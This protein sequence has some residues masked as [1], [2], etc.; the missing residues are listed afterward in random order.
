MVYLLGLILV[1]LSLLYSPSIEKSHVVYFTKT[2]TIS[3]ERNSPA[4][5]A[6]KETQKL[7]QVVKTHSEPENA[8]DS[9]PRLIA[10]LSTETIV[11]RT[12]EI[13]TVEQK[14]LQPMAFTRQELAKDTDEKIQQLVLAQKNSALY[15]AF[16]TQQ[17]FTPAFQNSHEIN[18]TKTGIVIR[19]SFELREGVGIVDHI[20]SLTRISD[21]RAL[22]LG[23]VDLRAGLYQIVVN[24]FEGELLA[25][26]KDKNGFLIGEDRQELAGLKQT[27]SIFQGP[28]LRLGKPSSYSFNARYADESRK[29]VENSNG[30]SASFFSGNYD[31][32][33]T[34]EDYPNVSRQSSTVGFIHDPKQKM[35]N[36]LTLRTAQDNT[37]TVLFS[38]LW[39]DGAVSYV[40]QKLQLQYSGQTGVIV[41]RIVDNGVPVENIRVAIDD[42]PG[43]EVFYLDD[44]WIPQNDKQSTSKNGYFFI[45][46]LSRGS[47]QISAYDISYNR[48]KGSQ[49]FVVDESALSYQEISF[50]K[51]S[52]SVSMFSYEAFTGQPMS[53]DVVLPGMEEVVSIDDAGE[54]K[55]R[56]NYRSGIQEIMIRPLNR[57]YLTYTTVRAGNEKFNYFPQ[58][59]E[60]WL[61]VISERAGVEVDLDKTV[62]VGFTATPEFTIMLA[63]DSYDSRNVVYFSSTG[64]F[65]SA[66]TIG[67]G[68]VFFNIPEG[69]HETVLNET[70]TQKVHS[71][72]FYAKPNR[73]YLAV[74]N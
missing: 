61:K 26:I 38:K 27:G 50:Q 24:S 16:G 58:I 49:L 65:T 9:K 29:M 45:P 47:Y 34:N 46:G 74:F 64:E 2:M 43:I 5:L 52:Q 41:G 15:N 17:S 48:N 72:V 31:L 12:I 1:P 22:E 8:I 14:N 66:P 73:I 35:I 21:G 37:E 56:T 63:D 40:S 67:G 62:F 36:T 30:L 19:G 53:A 3:Q 10:T 54:L 42:Q 18:G 33:R 20:V 44:F 68:V 60:N 25:E 51:N 69:L 57:E 23:Q 55:W 39:V 4:Y 70:N 71:R 6:F 59:S 28:S 32:E 13:A 7:N 11:P